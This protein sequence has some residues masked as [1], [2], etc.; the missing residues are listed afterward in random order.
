MLWRIKQNSSALLEAHPTMAYIRLFFCQLCLM[1]SLIKRIMHVINFICGHNGELAV[2]NWQDSLIVS[3]ATIPK[4]SLLFCCITTWVE[5]LF[6][7]EC[8]ALP[9][10]YFSKTFL[11]V[12]KLLN[13][14]YV[15]IWS[16]GSRIPSSP[17]LAELLF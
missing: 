6:E 1:M 7:F 8:V 13:S 11:A 16:C 12:H 3:L 5:C 14:K 17:L 4:R 10:C 15:S 2:S 9:C